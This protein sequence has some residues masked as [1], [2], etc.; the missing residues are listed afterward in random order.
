MEAKTTNNGYTIDALAQC[1][2]R[3]MRNYN[4]YIILS[5]LICNLSQWQQQRQPHLRKGNQGQMLMKFMDRVHEPATTILQ[6]STR[7]PNGKIA[8]LSG[9]HVAIA[10]ARLPDCL[11]AAA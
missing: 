4:L 9:S 6:H 10:I 8:N 11:L 7:G 1:T 2:I 3:R 5:K